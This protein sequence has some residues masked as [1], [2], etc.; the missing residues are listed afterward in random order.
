M[1]INLFLYFI[2]LLRS[3]YGFIRQIISPSVCVCMYVSVYICMKE[4][5]CLFVCEFVCCCCANCDRVCT[6]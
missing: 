3:H 1:V 4:C 2:S 6:H 5:V